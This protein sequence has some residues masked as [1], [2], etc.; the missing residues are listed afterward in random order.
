MALYSRED[1]HST[2]TFSEYSS[3][4]VAVICATSVHVLVKST[5]SS[6]KS[7]VFALIL[8][9]NVTIAIAINN[10]LFVYDS[11]KFINI[12]WLTKTKVIKKKYSRIN[13]V[14]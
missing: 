14:I 8:V 12:F 1:K 9:P 2:L 10:N 13:L 3:I 11:F 4:T 5:L 6:T 7:L